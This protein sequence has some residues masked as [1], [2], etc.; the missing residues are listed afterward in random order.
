MK[1]HEILHCPV[2][3]RERE[4]KKGTQTDNP[5]GQEVHPCTFILRARRERSADSFIILSNTD[6]MLKLS[7]VH[8]AAQGI[9]LKPETKSE[10]QK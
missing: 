8:P 1:V 4:E 7:R 5:T 9:A 2:R 3:E 6:V 10:H